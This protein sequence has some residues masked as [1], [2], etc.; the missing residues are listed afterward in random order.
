M[1]AQNPM[2]WLGLLALAVPIL[3]HLFSR[4]PARTAAFPSLRFLDVSRVLP[5]RRTQLSDLPL[6]LVRCAIVVFAVAALAQP[7]FNVTHDS[8]GTVARPR[9]IVLDTLPSAH[10]SLARATAMREVAAITQDNPSSLLICTNSP[11]QAMPGAIAWLREQRAELRDGL[12]GELVVI[13][14]FRGDALDS[15]DLATL[16]TDIALRLVRTATRSTH[17]AATMASVTWSTSA[18]AVV[19]DATMR[20]VRALNPTAFGDVAERDGDHHIVIASPDAD[21]LPA[22][23]RDARP[24]SAPWMGDVLAALHRDTNMS[25]AMPDVTI[26]TLPSARGADRLLL[27]SRA[28]SDGLATAALLLASSRAL[29]PMQSTGDTTLV[30]DERLRRWERAPSTSPRAAPSSASDDFEM[31]PSDARYFWLL[32]L[33][34]LGVETLM[35]RRLT[36]MQVTQR[37]T[38]D[39]P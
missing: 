26:A 31:G 18:T 34:L 15:L 25:G 36:A 32:V 3:V 5:T 10:D 19:V 4:K 27:L 38:T 12:R 11:R 30:S 14:H 13:S 8:R 29:A 9:V 7:L 1:R 39:T 28:P 24:L 2:A 20:A 6:L 37:P 22:W 33:L 21:S 17:A 35:R 23:T 16:P